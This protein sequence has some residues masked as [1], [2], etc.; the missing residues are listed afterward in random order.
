MLKPMT[1]WGLADHWREIG[2]GLAICSTPSHGGVFVAPDQR[3]Q[4]PAAL[5]ALTPF[6]GKPGWYEEDC[7][8]AIPV[9]AFPAY[10]TAKQVNDAADSARGTIGMW[11]H[12]KAV[13]A[14]LDSDDRDAILARAHV[15]SHN[16]ELR[17][18]A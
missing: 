15:E 14:W 2:T 11:Q 10:F 13:V 12:A 1:P 16:R 3:E 18:A 9:L 4:M 7:D 5:R 8:W 17:R 6:C